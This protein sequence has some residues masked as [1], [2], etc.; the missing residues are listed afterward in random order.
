[1]LLKCQ[2][3]ASDSWWDQESEGLTFVVQVTVLGVSPGGIF[4]YRNWHPLIVYKN[5]SDVL[6]MIS[7]IPFYFHIPP[8]LKSW[9]VYSVFDVYVQYVFAFCM[10]LFALN[11]P[12][13]VLNVPVLFEHY[14]K[15]LVPMC[16][17]CFNAVHLKTTAACQND[18]M[19]HLHMPRHLS[20]MD[21]TFEF[22]TTL[23]WAAVYWIT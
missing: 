20:L 19:V 5:L 9:R 14:S 6:L 15:P 18:W 11:P 7:L 23:M 21:I 17:V 13:G 1:M 22:P 16:N 2:L 8:A 12:S 3:S 10:H 4:A